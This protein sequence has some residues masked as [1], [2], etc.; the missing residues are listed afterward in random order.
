MKI[1]IQLNADVGLEGLNIISYHV[2]LIFW[3]FCQRQIFF[4]N[5][6]HETKRIFLFFLFF[7]Y[8]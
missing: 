4:W 3:K 5:I 7:L 2:F 6:E 1:W 8:A